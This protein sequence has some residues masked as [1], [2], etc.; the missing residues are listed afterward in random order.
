MP[1]ISRLRPWI[2]RLMLLI[3]RIIQLIHAINSFAAHHPCPPDHYWPA[4]TWLPMNLFWLPDRLH[5]VLRKTCRIKKRS[6]YINL[7]A[8]AQIGSHITLCLPLE[9]VP[10]FPL[11][12]RRFCE[13]SQ[14]PWCFKAKWNPNLDTED[15]LVHKMLPG[16]FSMPRR[17]NF[18]SSVPERDK[19]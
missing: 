8:P 19:I 1:L 17:E 7:K 14:H 12:S 13:F 18:L 4:L 15:F 16:W 6:H 5:S 3:N 9:H 2:I 11:H 10:V